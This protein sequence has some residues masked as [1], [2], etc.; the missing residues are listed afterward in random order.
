MEDA[1]GS[2]GPV[3]TAKGAMPIDKIWIGKSYQDRFGIFCE[4]LMTEGLY[5]AVCYFT[6]SADRPQPIELVR[7]LDWRHFSAAIGARITYLQ[8]LGLP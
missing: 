1:A 2:R 6:S 5:D 7:N 4:R 8:E 3:K